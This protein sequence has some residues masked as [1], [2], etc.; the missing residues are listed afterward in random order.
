ML[1]E[2]RAFLTAERRA[3][4]GLGSSRATIEPLRFLSRS[5]SMST[6]HK[7]PSTIPAVLSPREA[8]QHWLP[9]WHGIF[10]VAL[11]FSLILSQREETHTSGPFVVLLGLSVLLAIWYGFCIA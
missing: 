11:V 10:Y 3:V 7:R 8:W 9:L 2:Q 5:L 4:Q 6:S 1:V